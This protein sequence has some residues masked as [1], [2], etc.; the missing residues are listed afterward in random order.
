MEKTKPVVH[1]LPNVYEYV[2][3]GHGAVIFDVRDHPNKGIVGDMVRT[4]RVVKV[5]EHGSFETENTLY[6]PKGKDAPKE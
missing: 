3:E 2:A 5:W 4:S 1:Y 6:V